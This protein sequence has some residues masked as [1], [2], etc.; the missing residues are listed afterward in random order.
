MI[1]VDF[2]GFGREHGLVHCLEE[3]FVCLDFSISSK[4]VLETVKGLVIVSTQ[5][6]RN[7]MNE[8]YRGN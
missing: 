8:I 7:S 3:V 2:Q 6:E 5:T 1:T 4:L